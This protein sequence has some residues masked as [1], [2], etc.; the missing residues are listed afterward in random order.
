[1]HDFLNEKHEVIKLLKR[2]EKFEKI[3]EGFKESFGNGTME[4][5]FGGRLGPINDIMDN[6]EQ[7]NSPKEGD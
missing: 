3:W 4:N 7:K 5:E 1:V 6:Y 2:G